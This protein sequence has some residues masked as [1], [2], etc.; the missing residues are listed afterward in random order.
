MKPLVRTFVIIVG[1]LALLIIL[2]W[3][4]APVWQKLGLK[5]YCISGNWPNIEIT[6]CSNQLVETSPPVYLPAG[7][8]DGP[9][10][11]IVDDDG[12]PDGI[13]ALL[14]LLSNP[15]YD[16]HAVTISYGEAHPEVFAGH[17]AMILAAFGWPDIPVGYGMDAPLEGD[18]SFPDSWRERSNQFWGISIPDAAHPTTP[19]PAPELIVSTVLASDQPVT[20]FVS[21]AHTNLAQALR[22]DPRIAENIHEVFI[23]GGSIDVPGNIHSVWPEFDNT[24]AEWNIW[25]DPLAASEVFNSGLDL[26]QVPLDATGQVIWS[27]ADIRKW[28]KN[29]SPKSSLAADLGQ[30][31]LDISQFDGVYVWDLTTAALASLPALCPEVSMG[32]EVVTAAGPD[33]GRTRQVDRIPNVTVCL[34]PDSLKVK[35][36]VQTLFQ[37]P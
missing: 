14:F 18:N 8:T 36:L 22:L 23:M 3:P 20:I 13:V 10:P 4:M 33:Q 30:M 29:Y 24:T 27:R 26:H 25:V 6:T 9:I 17:V 7:S 32:L 37:Y 2:I 1:F 11:L 12:S 19:V 35:S 21:G 34:N 15:N 31:M 5:P 28:D 16:I